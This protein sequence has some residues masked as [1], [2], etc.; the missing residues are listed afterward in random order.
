MAPCVLA[1]GDYASDRHG[2][3]T[4][5]WDLLARVPGLNRIDLIATDGVVAGAFHERIHQLLPGI[6]EVH[7]APDAEWP[8][9]VLLVPPG[10]VRRRRAIAKRKSRGL[11]GG[12]VM[13]FAPEMRCPRLAGSRWSSVGRFPMCT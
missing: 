5:H 9:P 12:F 11:R 1:V 6:E 13:R 7:L 4:A 3:L 2:L 8:A 10:G